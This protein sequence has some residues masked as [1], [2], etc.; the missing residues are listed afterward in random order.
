MLLA[1]RSRGRMV[2]AGSTTVIQEG[3]LVIVYESHDRMKAVKVSAKET[4]QNRFG[5][6][7]HSDWIG[8]P[9]GSKVHSCTQGGFV[10]LLAP[11]PELWTLV[12]QHRTQILYA[13]DISLVVSFLE[14]KPGSVVLESG[15][16]S[17]SLTT[18]LAR[19]VAPTGH[20]HTFEFHEP[21]AIAAREEFLRNGLDGLVTVRVRDVEAQGLPAELAGQA[22]AVFLDLP[23]PWNAVP[24]A[25][26]VL[27]PD[28]P[29]CSFSPCIE[30]VQRTC[31]ELAAHGFA[32]VRAFEILL[33]TY[34]VRS[35]ACSAQLLGAAESVPNGKRT[36]AQGGSEQKR[37][38]SDAA[39]RGVND[40][41]ESASGTADEGEG[42]ATGTRSRASNVG[43]VEG[44]AVPSGTEGSDPAPTTEARDA[45]EE[46]SKSV[47]STLG[48]VGKVILARPT[49]ETRGHTGYLTFARRAC[50]GA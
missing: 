37:Q 25:A 45:T 1:G 2:V 39:Q 44:S 6:F 5:S 13:P 17:G 9:F 10:H 34:D 27:R 20:V 36:K 28:A 31:E 30:Q 14:L 29:F 47:P 8:R 23:G 12:L 49:A 3:D 21:R 26:R 42:D 48:S 22:D 19:A 4:L 15:T 43:K 16:G 41:S 33:R 18:C 35:E 38:K 11:T 40:R 50:S 32:D 24:S 46:Q 7:K